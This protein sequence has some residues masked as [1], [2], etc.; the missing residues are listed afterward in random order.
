MKW[1]Q[2]SKCHDPELLDTLQRKEE[3]PSK[4][5]GRERRLAAVAVLC[6]GW[7]RVGP[8]IACTDFRGRS[9]LIGVSWRHEGTKPEMKGGRFEG[10]RRGDYCA[11][12]ETEFSEWFGDI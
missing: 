7:A 11:V 8:C 12:L 3:L 6:V 10:Q 2:L 5:R 1:I 9:V 4:E